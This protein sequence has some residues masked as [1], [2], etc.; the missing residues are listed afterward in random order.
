[1]TE[2]TSG[3][4]RES[5]AAPRSLL[6]ETAE[7]VARARETHAIDLFQEAA[8]RVPAYK[9]FLKKNGVSPDRIRTLAD[10]SSVPPI[11]KKN[12]LSQY[13]M[14]DLCWDGTLQ[15]KN[16]V[17]TSTS[18]STGTP[19]Y[20][21]RDATLDHRSSLLF[22]L[23]LKGISGGRPRSTLFIV[24][25]GMGVWIGGIITYQSLR[26][27]AERGHPVSMIT[28]GANKK[29]V[30]NALTRLAP[31]YDQ[32]VLGGYPPFVKDVLDEA[33]KYGF[34]P[35]ARPLKLLFAAEAFS[36]TFRDYVL[37]RAGAADPVFETANIY[38]TADIGTMAIETPLSIALRRRALGD[39]ALY[40]GLFSDATKLPTLAQFHPAV[41]H[42]EEQDGQLFVTGDNAL[43]LI[44]YS[45]GDRG[46]VR[47]YDEVLA[48]A[49]ASG[50]MK[51]P[52]YAD[53]LAASVP[54]PFV[55]VYERT[56][57]SVKLYGAIVYAEHVR[58]ALQIRELEPSVTGKFSMATLHDSQ[59]TE[60]LSVDVELKAGVAEGDG[61][62]RTLVTDAI[63]ATL[64][65][66]NAEYRYLSDNLGDRV[67]PDVTLWTYEHPDRFR[68]GGKQQWVN[69]PKT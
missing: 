33:P 59:E 56:D 28:P 29:E 18:G 42:F 41:T 10:L 36:E 4:W 23:Y 46:G 63:V 22:E 8:S 40:A 24:S 1:M 48:L 52:A 5:L 61:Q 31:L 50:A 62:L 26:M 34:D 44:R 9:D 38:G 69:L 65:K 39:P 12:Y 3:A 14:A 64:R 20:F 37:R 16:L 2:D 17:F 43:P 53:A 30:F 47:Q 54:L 19:F 6:T 15:G 58:E 21:P 67:R 45:L 55:Y 7:D 35:A 49:E 68:P 57:F 27:L 25:F 51:D 32:V 66:K 60:Y 11:D 13:A